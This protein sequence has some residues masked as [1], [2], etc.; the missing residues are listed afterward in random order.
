MDKKTGGES[1]E[2][3]G[4]SVVCSF[5]KRKNLEI[6]LQVLYPWA[7]LCPEQFHT[8]LVFASKRL[9]G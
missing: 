4:L 2:A 9:N 7:L 3:Y 6:A 8:Q 1:A 5:V